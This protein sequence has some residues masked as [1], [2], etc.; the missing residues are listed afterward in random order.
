MDLHSRAENNETQIPGLE[1]DLQGLREQITARERAG[2][3]LRDR[4]L[5]P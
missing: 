4:L 1:R 2:A 5:T 3:T